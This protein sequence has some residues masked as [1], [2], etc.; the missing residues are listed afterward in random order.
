MIMSWIKSHYKWALCLAP[1]LVSFLF[2]LKY[3]PV[4]YGFIL[5]ELFIL[6]IVFT[7]MSKHINKKAIM[8]NIAVVILALFFAETY[9]AGW[10]D[11]IFSMNDNKIC[12]TKNIETCSK[13][14]YYIK[15]EI[16]GYSANPGV[17][18]ASKSI[19]FDGDIIY[20][21]VYNIDNY[22]LRVTPDN[23]N[24]AA[25]NVLFFGGSFTL[26]AGVNDDETLPYIFQRE[27]Q[28]QYKSY[29]FGFHGYGPHQMLRI[30]DVGLVE[31][32]LREKKAAIAIYQA[33]IEHID[34]SSGG[35]PYCLWDIN[36]PE[37]VLNN[38]EIEYSGKFINHRVLQRIFTQLTKSHLVQKALQVFYKRNKN[39]MDLFVAV[40][41]E[42][43]NLL[44]KKF[45]TDFIVVLWNS[46]DSVE[47]F[48]YVLSEL[49]RKKIEVIT[50][51][52]SFGN[53]NGLLNKQRIHRCEKHPSGTANR[54]IATYLL[55][56]LK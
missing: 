50:T 13:E 52:D 24:P 9:F 22:G 43:R 35:Y 45:G 10:Y 1:V 56:Y 12:K 26:G 44:L 41:E 51:D 31:D 55:D 20:D 21:V 34:R 14:N 33:I 15:D 16:R 11:N 17:S 37:Y 46:E 8:F 30:I 2:M 6:L 54:K 36:G 38:N 18:V 32:I 27:S 19:N 40:I 3:V 25:K 49:K 39:D 42:S 5:L 28:S 23:D 7:I 48:D 29:N 53:N 4:P 47:D